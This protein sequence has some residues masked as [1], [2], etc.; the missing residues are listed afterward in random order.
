MRSR[1]GVSLKRVGSGGA[2]MKALYLSYWS[3]FHIWPH[4]LGCGFLWAATRGLL[5]EAIPIAIRVVRSH[6]LRDGATA[7]KSAAFA[8]RWLD[9]TA[10]FTAY[11]DFRHFRT[12]LVGMPEAAKIASRRLRRLRPGFLRVFL[13][14][15]GMAQPAGGKRGKVDRVFARW[16]ASARHGPGSGGFTDY[17]Y[18]PC[19]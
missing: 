10:Q 18:W 17:I 8:L 2:L 6:V 19:G 9:W 14:R 5:V 1:G 16:R 4:L 7:R 13:S 15:H 11:N 3:S 12:F